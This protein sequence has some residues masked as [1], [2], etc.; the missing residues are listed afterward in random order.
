MLLCRILLACIKFLGECPCPRCLIKK[1]DV[2]KMGTKLDLKR[3]KTNRRIDDASRRDRIERSR[4]LIF[5]KGVGINS[6]HIKNFLQEDS[7]VPTRVSV[8]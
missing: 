8:D 6:Q 3:R 1:A 7:L 4:A 5:Q 2:P